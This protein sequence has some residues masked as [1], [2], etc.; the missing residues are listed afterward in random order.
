MPGAGDEHLLP[1]VVVVVVVVVPDGPVGD[2]VAAAA[3]VVAVA[4][5]DPVD[6]VGHGPGAARRGG[7]RVAE[8][9]EVGVHDAAVLGGGVDYLIFFFLMR[10]SPTQQ[11]PIFFDKT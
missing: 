6:E 4:P 9:G 11:I 8:Q 2:P 10:L 7:H 3:A 1:V 5:L